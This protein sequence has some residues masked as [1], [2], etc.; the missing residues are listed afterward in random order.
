MISYETIEVEF[1]TK[2]YYLSYKGNNLNLMT[3]LDLSSNNL[4]G[5]IPSEIGEL[6]EI[7]ALNLLRNRLSGSIQGTFSNLINI[8]SLDLSYNNLSGVIPQNLTDLY[9]LAIFNVS[10]NKFFGTIPTTM[11]FANFDEDNYRGNSDLCG[12]VINIICNHTSTFSPAST[13]QHQTAHQTAIDME[14]FYWSC[15][16][17]YVSAIIGLTVILWVNSHWCR[18][19]F[20]YVDLCIFYCF[21]RCSK[22]VFH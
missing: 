13:T 14:S 6:R 9:S 12:S 15:A 17:S 4:S 7:I 16:A 19:W 11:Q 10:Y 20:H 22:N 18:A 5:S 21:S 3:G 8:E 1:R 2:S